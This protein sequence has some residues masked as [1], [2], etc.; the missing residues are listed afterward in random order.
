MYV[1]GGRSDE[2]GYYHTNKDK[3]CSELKFLNLKK[4]QWSEVKMTGDIPCGRRSHSVC[5]IKKND[6]AL[7]F[8]YF[9]GL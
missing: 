4:L 3:Y 2:A 5:M 8:K 6:I 1:F 7:F 9:R